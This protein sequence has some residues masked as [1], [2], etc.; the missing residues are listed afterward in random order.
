MTHAPAHPDLVR[1]MEAGVAGRVFPGAA[2][3]V[4]ARGQIVHLSC[5]GRQSL[6][7]PAG[8]VDRHTCFDLASLTKVLAT[9]PLALLSV[10]RGR[11]A[12]DQPVHSVL[13]GY[14]GPGWSEI[15]VRMLLDHTSGLPAWRAY[16]Q[17]AASADVPLPS[18]AGRDFVRRRIAA[19]APVA[20]PGQATVYSDLNFILLDEILEAVNGRATDALF[21][22][23]LAEPLGLADLFFVDLKAPMHAERARRGRAFAATERCP[24]RGRTLLGEVH[25]ENAYAMGGVSGHAGLFGTVEDV[26]RMANAWQASYFQSDALLD[27]D[28]TREFWRRTDA[29]SATRALGF[30]TPSPEGSQAGRHFGPRTVGHLGFTGTSLWIDPDR[31]LIVVLL[32]NR[33]HPTRENEAIRQFRPALHDCVGELW[34]A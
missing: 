6:D 33:V 34:P 9:T 26:G 15:T 10:Q 27:R 5:H 32:T 20:P 16:Y 13:P 31:A 11:L 14:A 8:P 28:L 1:L 25:D 19:E 24:W 21:S 3:L 30:D 2:L 22:D 18:A 23:W 17:E 29:P 7:P 12:L 4:Q